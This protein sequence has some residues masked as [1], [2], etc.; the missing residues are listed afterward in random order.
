MRFRTAIVDDLPELVGVQQEGAIAGLSNIFPQDVYPFPHE[1]VLARWAEELADDQTQVFV[2]TDDL[3]G[4][5]GFAAIRADELL[6]FGTAVELWGT[7]V[8]TELHDALLAAF[9]PTVDRARLRVY[10]ENRRA[11]RFYEKLGWTATGRVSQSAFPPHA[12]LLEYIR[13]LR[14]S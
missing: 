2:A 3:G 12:Q 10:T 4:I 7:G 14:T 9:P 11:R 6:H 8:A 1:A 5:T 13:N